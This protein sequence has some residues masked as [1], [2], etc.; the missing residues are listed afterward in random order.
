MNF[1]SFSRNLKVI[2]VRVHL[3]CFRAEIIPLRRQ[4]FVLCLAGCFVLSMTHLTGCYSFTGGSVPAHLKTLSIPL[5]DDTS[6]FGQP[7][8][9]E[10]LTQ[11]VIQNFR[12]E[13][14]FT[15]VEDRSDAA[16][17]LAITNISEATATVQQGEVERD[18]QVV[19]TVN[20]LYEDRVK[21]KVLLQKPFAATIAYDISSGL[22]GRDAALQRAL[23]QVA[24]DILL[25]VVSGW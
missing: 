12:R 21:Q 17:T 2:I 11:L 3:Y 20:V 15:L 13:N 5:A 7:Q 19:I 8:L 1:L 23:Q 14:A 6:G 10:T 16:I 24:N 22:Q 9:R 25:G 4:A 18:K